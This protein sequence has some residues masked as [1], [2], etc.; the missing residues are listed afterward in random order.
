MDENGGKSLSCSSLWFIFNHQAGNSLKGNLIQILND[1]NHL[2]NNLYRW[3]SSLRQVG[4]EKYAINFF[5]GMYYVTG[6][7]VL[8]F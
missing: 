2:Y 8:I 1:K 6:M 5:T 7:T 3:M 4:P